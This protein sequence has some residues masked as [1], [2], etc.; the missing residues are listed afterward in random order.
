MFHCSNCPCTTEIGYERN[1]R[2]GQLEAVKI[3]CELCFARLFPS[4]T[5]K[6]IVKKAAGGFSASSLFSSAHLRNSSSSSSSSSVSSVIQSSD[7]TS[8]IRP[9]CFCNITTYSVICSCP[10]EKTK[11]CI[12]CN[13]SQRTC[14][15]CR[16][17]VQYNPLKQFHFTS[18]TNIIC[19]A[20][21]CLVLASHLKFHIQNACTASVRF[22]EE[23]VKT[24]EE[25]AKVTESLDQSAYTAY[26]KKIQD[27]YDELAETPETSHMYRSVEVDKKRQRG[28]YEELDLSTSESSKKHHF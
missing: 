9:C 5:P 12:G 2:S 16:C 26:R 14:L 24:L 4:E 19:P 23:F 6:M 22:K 3:Y 25:S 21:R 27:V 28:R 18:T 1:N 13:Q 7:K 20:C 11:C 17:V 8:K 15:E 10:C